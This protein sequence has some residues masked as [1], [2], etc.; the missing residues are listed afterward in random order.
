M[1]RVQPCGASTTSSWWGPA[2]VAA[3][4]RAASPRRACASCV[5]ERGRRFGPGDFPERPDQAPSAL[6]HR[7]GE[8]RRHLRRPAHARRHVITAA[9]VG[10]G[11][12]V[13][14]N[15]QLRA[16]ADVFDDG[17]PA[18]ITPADARAVVRPDRG[19]ARAA[20]TPPDPPLDKVRAFAAM[21]R[22]AGY[23]ADA[24]PIAV[25]FGDA[26]RAPVQRRAPGRAA[27]TWRAATS[28]A[29]CCRRT[30]S[31]SPTSRGPRR[32][33]RGPPASPRHGPAGTR[34]DGRAVDR[35]V[36]RAGG[37][38]AP[39]HGPGAARSSSRRGRSGRR[40]FC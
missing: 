9:G 26:P 30:R 27:R 6:F 11:S 21:A 40:G 36:P 15:V 19:G 22:R 7:Q 31:T 5:L 1:G 34:A 2:S 4:P 3:S 10:G 14:A 29:R 17:W 28:A 20:D 32:T 25:H 13:Y 39:R 23:E 37:R 35:R 16:P 12:L 24:L 33:A 38:A 18:A 8:P